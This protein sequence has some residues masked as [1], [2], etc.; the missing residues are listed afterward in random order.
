GYLCSR[1]IEM[2]TESKYMPLVDVPEPEDFRKYL[3][4]L[5]ESE[6]VPLILARRRVNVLDEMYDA[7]L[8]LRDHFLATYNILWLPIFKNPYDRH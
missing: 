8:T 7:I 3:L 6:R 2:K 5:Y 4:N 1:A